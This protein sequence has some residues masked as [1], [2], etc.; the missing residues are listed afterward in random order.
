VGDKDVKDDQS[1]RDLWREQQRIGHRCQWSARDDEQ[2]LF[3]RCLPGLLDDEAAARRWLRHGIL[4]LSARRN[5]QHFVGSRSQVG[6]VFQT[7]IARELQGFSRVIEA[8]LHGVEIALFPIPHVA[9]DDVSAQVCPSHADS[10]PKVVVVED[11]KPPIVVVEDRVIRADTGDVDNPVFDRVLGNDGLSARHPGKTRNEEQDWK[12]NG[13]FH[14]E[15]MRP[16]TGLGSW[17]LPPSPST[18]HATNSL[19][20]G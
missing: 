14:D 11:V 5:P 20:S 18:L 1:G 13:A 2:R 15:I 6:D 16:F 10:R 8:A 7:G 19:M 12:W 3:R 4:D 9:A 17:I